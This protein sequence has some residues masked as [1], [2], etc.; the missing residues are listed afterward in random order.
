[1][2]GPIGTGPFPGIFITTPDGSGYSLNQV[3]NADFVCVAPAV[4]CAGT[5]PSGSAIDTSSAGDHTFQVTSTDSARTQ[6]TRTV[7]Y[8]VLAGNIAAYA[9]GGDT[10]T[11]DPGNVG[12]SIEVPVQTSI[13][14]PTGVSAVLQVTS[15]ATT[16]D[17]PTGFTLFG[18]EVVLG[19][20]G[21]QGP[22]SPDLPY[23]VTFTV[24]SSLLGGIDP[25]DVQ[26][27]RNGVALA[28]C[29]DLS[30]AV[31]DPCIA[32][33]GAAPGGGGD[34]LVT[35]RTSHFSTWS[36]GK[37]L[38]YNLSGPFPPV[39]APPAVNTAKAG[40][41]IPVKFKLGGDKGLGVLVSGYPKTGLASCGSAATD[42]IEQTVSS[43]TS[44]LTYD[45][46]STQYN[47]TWKTT[48]AMKGCRDLVL[49]FRDGSTLRALFNLR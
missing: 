49:K 33:Q 3:V 22:V 21:R 11:T 2:P 14:V 40:S 48:T 16:T 6:V 39:D 5:V 7:Y 4:S 41:A 23:Q 35:V 46:V 15:Q 30:S 17:A 42:E 26:V 38:Y 12:A 9:G 45:P 32:S 20:L 34:A 43:A 24:D 28:A 1:V 31:P 27:F 36:L 19:E 37:R 10:I 25:G 13:T 47:Y 18:T 8:T 29:T 44:A